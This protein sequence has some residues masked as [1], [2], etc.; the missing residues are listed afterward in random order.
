VSYIK[1]YN[2]NWFDDKTFSE[3]SKPDI[4]RFYSVDG[5]FENNEKSKT[6]SII[7]LKIQ[8]LYTIKLQP[9]KYRIYIEATDGGKV[10]TTC[11]A[12]ITFSFEFQDD[13]FKKSMSTLESVYKKPK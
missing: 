4:I 2:G 10:E 9:G 13:W 1:I 12:S 5:V 6:F 3:Q 8:N 7:D 11:L